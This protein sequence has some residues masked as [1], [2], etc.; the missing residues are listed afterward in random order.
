[1]GKTGSHLILCKRKFAGMTILKSSVIR[2]IYLSVTLIIDFTRR[3]RRDL[4]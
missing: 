1:M 4:Q 2:A 3:D